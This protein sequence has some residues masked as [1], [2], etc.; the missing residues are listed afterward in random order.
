M[1]Y[2]A[3]QHHKFT[4]RRA[5]EHDTQVDTMAIRLEDIAELPFWTRQFFRDQAAAYLGTA[6]PPF[7]ADVE[8]G[9]WPNPI[10]DGK[11]PLWNRHQ[12]NEAAYTFSGYAIQ[13]AHEREEDN[14]VRRRDAWR[15]GRQHGH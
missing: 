6:K 13:S 11:R 15:A 12:L 9:T 5:F 3:A 7:A 10:N 1:A 4:S 8:N 2:L 14:W